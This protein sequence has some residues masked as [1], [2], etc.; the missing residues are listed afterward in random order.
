MGIDM[1]TEQQQAID[2]QR[3]AIKENQ[4]KAKPNVMDRFEGN[5][6]PT[7]QM[8]LDIA[9]CA[10]IRDIAYNQ[11]ANGYARG[12]AE[13]YFT[14]HHQYKDEELKQAKKIQIKYILNNITHLRGN[15][16]AEARQLLKEASK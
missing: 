4:T 1:K 6:E 2:A 10:A 3:K 5:D 12:Y 14:L 13:T 15:G 8:H 16:V 7:R 11:K 9:V